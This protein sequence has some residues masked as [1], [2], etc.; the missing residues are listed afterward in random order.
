[1]Q[2]LFTVYRSPPLPILK[3]FVSLVPF[4]DNSYSF[5]QPCFSALSVT[6]ILVGKSFFDS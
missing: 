6:K 2:L 5:S 1:M 3:S 4:V